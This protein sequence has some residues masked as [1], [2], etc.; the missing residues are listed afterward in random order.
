M[1][2]I[3]VEDK[4]PGKDGQTH[5]LVFCKDNVYV[6]C[7]IARFNEWGWHYATHETEKAMFGVTHWMELPEKP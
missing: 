5:Y 6:G 3:D 4:L 7:E 2:W 1:K